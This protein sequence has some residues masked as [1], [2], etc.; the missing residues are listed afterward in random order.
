MAKKPY[1]VHSE[2]E[3]STIFK[4]RFSINNSQLDNICNGKS[5]LPLN[6]DPYDNFENLSVILI[7]SLVSSLNKQ[8]IY[9]NSMYFD[10]LKG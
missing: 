3:Q 5:L 9:V 1:N 2:K 4:F 8:T 6:V 10:S 7:V